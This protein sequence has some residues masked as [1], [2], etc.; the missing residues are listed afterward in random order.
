MFGNIT[1]GKNAIIGA[2]SVV[3]KSIPEN[4]VV[5]GVPAKVISYRG[6]LRD[7]GETMINEIE[8]Y[9]KLCPIDLLQFYGFHEPRS[10]SLN[11]ELEN[12]QL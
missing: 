10:T 9:A 1:I 4:A 12:K 6:N 5:T 8:L 3:T 11:N 7:H 2:N